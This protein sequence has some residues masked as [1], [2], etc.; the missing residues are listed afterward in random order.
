MSEIQSYLEQLVAARKLF[1]KDQDN[2]RGWPYLCVE[3]FV[4]RN[5]RYMGNMSPLPNGVR[6][7]SL[8]N[9]FKNA[10]ELALEKNWT[11][12]EG[13]AV[14]VIPISHAWVLDDKG[15]VIDPTW[16]EGTD[17]F[18]VEIPLSYATKTILRREAYGVI[19]AWEIGYPLLKG[20]EVIGNVS[21]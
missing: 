7:G 9:C 12:C 8:G 3:D 21:S 13:Y 17:Y 4:L 1:L 5:G 6:R 16:K 10:F 20:E 15:N 14:A 11:Y 18:G 2:G 19:D